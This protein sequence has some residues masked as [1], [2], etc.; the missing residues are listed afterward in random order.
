MAPWLKWRPWGAMTVR[1]TLIVG[2]GISMLVPAVA[3][4]P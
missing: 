2:T 3:V 1:Q 4:T